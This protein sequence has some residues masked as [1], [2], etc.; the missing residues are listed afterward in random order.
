MSTKFGA[1]YTPS[2]YACD[3]EIYL[4]QDMFYEYKHVSTRTHSLHIK[5]VALVGHG[6]IYKQ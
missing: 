6:Y 5:S 2:W 1:D 3:V 4:F